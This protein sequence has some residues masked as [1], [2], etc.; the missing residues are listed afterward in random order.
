MTRLGY[1]RSAI[2]SSHIAGKA[3]HN[4][5]NFTNLRPLDLRV[6]EEEQVSRVFVREIRLGYSAGLVRPRTESA[7]TFVF[8][9]A[10]DR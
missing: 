6:A 1:K 4:G 2:I 8:R 10:R 9:T 7:A 5:P 3:I